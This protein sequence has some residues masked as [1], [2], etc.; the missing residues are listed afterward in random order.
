MGVS[1]YYCQLFN[2]IANAVVF[3]GMVAAILYKYEGQ[4]Q[5]YEIVKKLSLTINN[6]Q[7]IFIIIFNIV[8]Y[9]KP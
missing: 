7:V 4:Y 2:G 5:S 3:A 8:T 1:R 9:L 6:R